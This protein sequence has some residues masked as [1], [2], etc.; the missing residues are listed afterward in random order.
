MSLIDVIDKQSNKL[1]SKS[2]NME[3]YIWRNGTFSPNNIT[4]QNSEWLSLINGISNSISGNRTISNSPVS[5]TP[6]Y[7]PPNNSNNIKQQ[8]LNQQQQAINNQK[9][10]NT[11]L[12]AQNNDLINHQK[13]MDITNTVFNTIGGVTNL[14]LGIWQAIEQNK[15]IGDQRD[16]LKKQLQIAEEDRLYRDKERKRLDKVRGNTSKQFS[17]GAV[18]SRSY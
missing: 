9:E 13:N 11:Q 12:L 7:N 1:V 18:I 8:W 10:Y 16:L 2:G 3:Q 15:L 17:S 14:G 5:S 4:A 6:I